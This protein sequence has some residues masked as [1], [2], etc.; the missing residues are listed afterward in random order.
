MDVLPN[1]VYAREAFLPMSFSAADFATNYVPFVTSTEAPQRDKGKAEKTFLKG[2]SR[3]RRVFETRSSGIDARTVHNR[4]TCS[5]SCASAVGAPV[6]CGLGSVRQRNQ[7]RSKVVGW[8][9]RS[10]NPPDS[11]RISPALL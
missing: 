9:S 7:I 4:T 11:Q 6:P 1:T 8:I 2:T 10:C 3:K 5:E